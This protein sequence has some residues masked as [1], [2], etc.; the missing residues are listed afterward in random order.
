MR[1]N[2][3]TI[4]GQRNGTALRA[5]LHA[6][7]IRHSR[8]ALRFDTRERRN[9]TARSP[10]LDLSP[11]SSA[12]RQRTAPPDGS[13]RRS[14][15]GRRNSTAHSPALDH[16][17]SIRHSRTALRSG[18]RN[19]TALR[20][21]LHAHSIRHSRTA[22]RFDHADGTANSTANS[23]ANDTAGQPCASTADSIRHRRTALRADHRTAD[24]TTNGTAGRLCASI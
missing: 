3:I 18:Q 16:A 1:R 23:A 15:H 11:D 4:S 8:T 2:A 12:L 9:G 20:T 22:L 13:A 5:D 24:G 6:H 21:D 19:G 10:A 17:H 14:T 7:S